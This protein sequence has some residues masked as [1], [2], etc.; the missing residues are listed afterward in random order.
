MKL[1]QNN[2]KGFSLIELVVT[3]ALIAIAAT[4]ITASYLNT[5]EENR[6]EADMS[7]LNNIDNSLQQIMIYKDAFKEASQLV[8][9]DN[10]LNF[11]FP[12]HYDQNSGKSM[13][14]ISQAKL[15]GDD[16]N[17]TK[18]IYPHLKEFIGDTIELTSSTYKHGEYKVTLEFDGV[19]LS[20]VRDYSISNDTISISN[21]GDEYMYQLE[22]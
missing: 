19:K 2:K 4:F 17:K 5:L 18:A 14:I 3:I 10:K 12:L 15:N 6:M 22:D 16:L 11:V 13:I 7:Q 8:V 9:D 1:K 21:S 20:S